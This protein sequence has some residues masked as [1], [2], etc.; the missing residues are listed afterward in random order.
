ML[1]SRYL[2]QAVTLADGRVL[3]VGGVIDEDDAEGVLAS[4]EIYDPD[5]GTWHAG[6][7]IPRGP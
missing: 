4:V 5:S 1:Q 2:H 6:P 3:V 7:D